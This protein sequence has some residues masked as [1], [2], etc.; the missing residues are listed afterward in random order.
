[1]DEELQ[2][3]I[4]RRNKLVIAAL[5]LCLFYW[6]SVGP[7]F[8][9]AREIGRGDK[10]VRTIYAPLF[11]LHDHTRL[12]TPLK[13]LRTTLGKGDGEAV[14]PGGRQE[15]RGHLD[16]GRRPASRGDRG[17]TEQPGTRSDT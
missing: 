8:Y 9:V 6:L 15:P 7:A 5:W 1:M 17:R 11:W 14:A 4:P 16:A 3:S 10:W 12:D 2:F 13:W